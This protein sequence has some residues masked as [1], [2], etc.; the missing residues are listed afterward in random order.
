MKPVRPAFESAAGGDIY[1]IM[2]VRMRDVEGARLALEA[3]SDPFHL[4]QQNASP[5]YIAACMNDVAMLGLLE[6]YGAL[7]TINDRFTFEKL[8]P[9]FGAVRHGAKDAARWLLSKGA[10]INLADYRNM[11]ALHQ[12]VSDHDVSLAKLLVEE[13]CADINKIANPCEFTALHVAIFEQ[14]SHMLREMI[15]LGGDPHQKDDQGRTP[16]QMAA[17]KGSLD[18]VK[19]LMNEASPSMESQIEALAEAVFYE[20]RDVAYYMIGQDVEVNTPCK[21]GRYIIN[22]ATQKDGAMMVLHLLEAGADPDA[23]EPSGTFPLLLATQRGLTAIADLLLE[24]GADIDKNG[25]WGTAL[26]AAVWHDNADMVK[27]LL[28]RGASPFV[29]D[30]N[31]R[32]PLEMAAGRKKSEHLLPLLEEARKHYGYKNTASVKNRPPK[33][34]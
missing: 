30:E 28:A 32:T 34:S 8:T 7:K 22:A 15:R 12:A 19:V 2:A 33:I 26:H 3:G 29:K 4:T 5:L 11:T 18:C 13:G 17:W 16:L 6:E 21:S 14:D 25:G 9:L 20:H 24:H 10:M 23:T 31:G 1:L 27:F